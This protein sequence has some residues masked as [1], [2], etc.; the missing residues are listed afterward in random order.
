MESS[1]GHHLQINLAIKNEGGQDG[2]SADPCGCY[3]SYSRSDWAII[4]RIV[5]WGF[6]PM[7][8]AKFQACYTTQDRV[9]QVMCFH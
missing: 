2:L 8:L 4:G 9:R 7:A 6:V 1:P 3:E 5:K